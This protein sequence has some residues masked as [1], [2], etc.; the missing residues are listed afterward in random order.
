MVPAGLVTNNGKDGLRVRLTKKGY[1]GVMLSFVTSDEFVRIKEEEREVEDLNKQNAY[2]NGYDTVEKATTLNVVQTE[3]ASARGEIVEEE[4]LSDE[5][6]DR[7]EAEF[8]REVLDGEPIYEED[9]EQEIERQ[10]VAF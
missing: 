3:A 6:Y 9:F 7:L 2:E 1:E 5:E 8:E 4:E 10:G